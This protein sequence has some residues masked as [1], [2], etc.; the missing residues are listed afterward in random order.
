MLELVTVTREAERNDWMDPL[1][2]D[3]RLDSEALWLLPARTDSDGWTLLIKG[4]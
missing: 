1:K 2:F 4:V 3:R